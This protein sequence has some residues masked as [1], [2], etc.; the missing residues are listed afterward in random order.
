[1]ASGK[2]LRNWVEFL[3][4]GRNVAVIGGGGKTGLIEYLE[5]EYRSAGR[6]VLVSVT[7]R[8]GREQ[9]PGLGRL[10]AASLE[11]ALL[12]AERAGRG[13][14]ILLAGPRVSDEK[15]AG[16]PLDW[17]GPLRRA[18]GPECV[19]LV[20][21]DGSAGL[22]LKAHREDEPLPPPLPNLRLVGVVGLSVL[23]K[24][25]EEA[26]HR[27]E[28]MA[29]HIKPPPAGRPLTP[30]LVSDFI[31]SS[32]TKIKP[33]V[34]FLNQ[35]DVL[36]TDEERKLGED[37]A[38]RLLEYGWVVFKGSLRERLAERERR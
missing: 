8:L 14:R 16:V 22:P 17:F 12:W 15:L 25:W 7:T 6:P 35:A 3:D 34:L 33:D 24:P 28:I 29:G 26:V 27:P 1:M 23:L 31:H 13:E 38:A 9:L 2:R 36:R 19:F 5:I 21:A 10:E 18:A 11:E 32:W 37:L 4:L 30:A 20:E